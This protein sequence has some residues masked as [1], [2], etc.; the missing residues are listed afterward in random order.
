VK[1]FLTYMAMLAA[2]TP[3]A[4]AQPAEP[5]QP[6]TARDL[7]ALHDF[8]RCVALGRPA[9]VREVL[10]LDPAVEGTTEQFIRLT[11]QANNC[12]SGR[13][14]GGGLMFRG[15]LAEALLRRDLGGRSIAAAT[16]F[17][18]A[19]PPLQAHDAAEFMGMCLIRT[20][21]AQ[22]EALFASPVGSGEELGALNAL[23]PHLGDCIP[24]GQNAALNL[25]GI[26]AA[27]AAAGYRLLHH[28]ANSTNASSDRR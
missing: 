4:F 12:T 22:V 7:R 6:T 19:L 8:A 18:P 26:R 13:L 2:A 9:R 16:A 11:D 15:A 20:H 14:M 17:N 10:M 23:R 28:N 27:L 25:H 21:P 1:L 24:Q 5:R 3:S